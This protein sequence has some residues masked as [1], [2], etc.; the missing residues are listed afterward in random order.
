MEV[1]CRGCGYFDGDERIHSMEQ[2]V[3][4]GRC[5]FSSLSPLVAYGFAKGKEILREC[6]DYM[7]RLEKQRWEAEEYR[8]KQEADRILGK[9]W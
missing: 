9:S 5:S 7:T 2:D 6:D 8:M 3:H 1:S 4:I